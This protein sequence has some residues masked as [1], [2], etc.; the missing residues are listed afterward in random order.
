MYFTHILSAFR[1]LCVVALA[2]F[3]TLAAIVLF[4]A[5]RF[6]I[7]TYRSPLRSVRCVPGPRKSHWLKGSFVDIQEG[8]AMRLLEEWVKTY[9]HVLKYYSFLGVRFFPSF[10]RNFNYLAFFSPRNSCS[11]ILL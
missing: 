3:V 10:D 4:V 6:R 2:L 9:G 11:L 5:I 8:D 7:R 1:F